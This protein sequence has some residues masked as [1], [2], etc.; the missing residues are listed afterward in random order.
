MLKA[1]E[2]FMKEA[3]GIAKGRYPKVSTRKHGHKP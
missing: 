2:E 1:K 3:G